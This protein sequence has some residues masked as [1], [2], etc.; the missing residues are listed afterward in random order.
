MVKNP[1]NIERAIEDRLDVALRVLPRDEFAVKLPH[2]LNEG[3]I[4]E[5]NRHG[6]S[7]RLDSRAKL[8]KC[9][10]EASVRSTPRLVLW[11][12]TTIFG[13]R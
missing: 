2:R 3:G 6:V 12:E 9:G 4:I 8:H 10:V 11:R 5:A 13:I 7:V 1:A